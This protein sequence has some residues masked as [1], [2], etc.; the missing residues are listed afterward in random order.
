MKKI[1]S[2]LIILTLISGCSNNDKTLEANYLQYKAVYNDLL[3]NDQFITTSAYYNFEVAINKEISST[4]EVLYRWSV[5]IDNPQV[6]MY[7][8][9]ALAIV[10]NL[11]IDEKNW[12]PSFGVVSNFKQSMIPNQVNNGLGFIKGFLLDS[13]V[14]KPLVNLRVTIAWYNETRTEQTRENFEVTKEY[15]EVVSQ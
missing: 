9:Q 3:D 4:G 14:T 7:D 10:N 11:Q 8:I 6:A 15:Q 1:I 12:M 13:T 5:I 2:L